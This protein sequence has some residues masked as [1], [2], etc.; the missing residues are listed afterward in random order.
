MGN[1]NFD[2]Q[3]ELDRQRAADA[4]RN[5]INTS[6]SLA[7][8]QSP[9]ATRAS[10]IA[11]Q[12]PHLTP[13]ITLALANSGYGPND[14]LTQSAAT[15]AAQRKVDNGIGWNSIGD[16]VNPTHAGLLHIPGIHFP[17]AIGTTIAKAASGIGTVLDDVTKVITAPVAPTL[18]IIGATAVSV[19]QLMDAA[20][21]RVATNSSNNSLKD[22]LLETTLGQSFKSALS[23]QGTGLGHGFLPG[24]PVSAAQAAASASTQT[25]N[26]A[27]HPYFSLHDDPNAP[28]TPHAG[29]TGR[30]VAKLVTEPGSPAF[31][32]LS[33]VIDAVKTITL[34]PVAKATKALGEAGEARKVFS[35]EDLGKS[36]FQAGPTVDPFE[37]PEGYKAQQLLINSARK[38]ID[39]QGTANF[40]TEHPWGRALVDDYAS[41]TSPYDIWR[42]S[43]GMDGNMTPALAHTLSTA[44]TPEEVRSVLSPV[45]GTDL[46]NKPA[47]IPLTD[48]LGIRDRLDGIRLLQNVPSQAAIDLEDHQSAAKQLVLNL[49]NGKAPQD[50]IESS[51]N[52]MAAAQTPVER[53]N[54]LHNALNIDLPRHIVAT[55]LSG[56]LGDID[57]N[58]NRLRSAFDDESAWTQITRDQIAKKQPIMG[59]IANGEEQALRSPYHDAEA[60]NRYFTAPDIR[61]IRRVSSTYGRLLILS[62]A[63]VPLAVLEHLQDLWKG[64]NISR[65]STMLRVTGQSQVQMTARGLDSPYRHILDYIAEASGRKLGTDILGESLNARSVAAMTDDAR[66]TATTSWANDLR[67]AQR[68]VIPY[69]DGRFTTSLANDIYDLHADPVAR[70]LAGFEPTTGDP[71]ADTKNWLS[72]DAGKSYRDAKGITPDNLSPYVQTIADRIKATTL[73]QDSLMS[74]IRDGHINPN[75]PPVPDGMTRLFRGGKSFE[76]TDATRQYRQEMIED[77]QHELANNPRMTEADKLVHQSRIDSLENEGRWFTSDPEYAKTF[78][79]ELVYK[80]VPNSVAEEARNAANV[81]NGRFAKKKGPEF[82]LGEEHRNTGISVVGTPLY[83]RD[84]QGAAHITAGFKNHINGLIEKGLTPDETIGEILQPV[85][86][87]ADGIFDRASR[88]MLQKILINPINHWVTTPALRQYYYEELGHVLPLMTEEA[89]SAAISAAEAAGLRSN[90]LADLSSIASKRAGD[91]SLEEGHLLTSGRAEDKLHS[92]LYDMHDRKQI[93]D[94]T[95]LIFPFGQAWAQQLKEWASLLKD[96]PNIIPRAET[97]IH[98]AEGS[99]FFYTDPKSGQESFAYPGSQF[100]TKALTGAPFRLTSPVAS[101]NMFSQNP[102]MPGFGPIAQTVVGHIIPDKPQFLDLKKLVAPFGA[103]NTL[104][105]FLPSYLS[106]VRTAFSSPDSDRAFAN[107]VWDTARYLASTGQYDISSPDGQIKLEDAAR[108]MAKKIYLFRAVAQFSLPSAPTPEDVAKDVNGQSV[109]VFKMSQDYYNLINEDK[110]NHTTLAVSRFIDEYGTKNILGMQSITQGDQP[111]ATKGFNWVLDNPDIARKYSSTYAFF[112][113]PGGGYSQQAYDMLF[114]KGKRK[115]LTV[116]EAMAAANTRVASMIYDHLKEQLGPKRTEAQSQWLDEKKTLLLAKYPGWNP[117]AFSTQTPARIRELQSA[118]ADPKLAS[119][120][121]TPALQAYFHFRDQAATAAGILGWKTAATT[122]PTR[123]WLRAKATALIARVP[124]FQSVYDELLSRELKDDG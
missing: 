44:S 37:N 40:L 4:T 30:N 84:G 55:D 97:L 51:F 46:L 72:S 83:T 53:A 59:L 103:P 16:R 95:R 32:A 1:L 121:I 23:G 31:N 88:K 7:P 91:L 58:F 67:Q 41:R 104:G 98:G 28:V 123:D 107:T 45:L 106:K 62:R 39:T 117:D 14:S 73:S 78:G 69:Y 89:Q 112:A 47:R 36:T 120:P 26:Y 2:I 99:G 60:V 25:L 93:M 29:T 19:P 61:T 85:D 102:L 94:I 12:Y 11:A 5:A 86:Q 80:D 48:T 92:T 108:S 118:A 115:I 109:L 52:Q 79:A 15:L 70:R 35:A 100:V 9:I 20:V 10:A 65:I 81:R 77:Y 111:L 13:G 27:N 38:T 75:L 34:D 54:V 43:G 42:R 22:E 122:K 50:L 110:L 24:G 71:I 101:L 113:P 105:D 96:R 119:N 90:K 87:V 82:L 74:A 64:L 76:E 114:E 33:G 17:E 3:S 68:E 56:P 21:R 18:R 8:Y 116:P 57:Y 124:E 63:E 66:Y 49:R 6:I